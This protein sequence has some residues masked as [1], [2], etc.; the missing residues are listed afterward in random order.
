[1][2]FFDDILIYSPTWQAHLAHLGA[3][4]VLLTQHKFV[5]NKK[6]C[7]FGLSS[8]DYLGHVIS[9]QGVEMDPSKV[10]AVLEWP[11]PTKVK[12]VRGFLG[13]TRYYRRFIK[14]YRKIAQPLT[15]ITKKDGFVW[16]KEQ[17]LAFEHL[18]Q[19]LASFPVL[20]LPDFSKEF[21][22]ECDASGQG[23]GAVLMQDRQ[24]IAYYSKAL[25]ASTL[26]K[27]VYEKEIMALALSVQHWRHYLLGRSF[28][29]Y[30][31]HRSLKH[32]LHQRITTTDQQCWLSD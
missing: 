9:A 26:S 20:A 32:L 21:I 13:L 12:G 19:C 18:K 22:I 2:V 28:K 1:M 6:K 15:I 30:I 16:D 11:T 27:S 25:A 31:D 8:I 5:A 24:P 23:I 10:Q 7:V 29:V 14:D 3:A 4:L 17:S